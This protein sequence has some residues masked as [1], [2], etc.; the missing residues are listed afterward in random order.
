MK[1]N[2]TIEISDE[3][4]RILHAALEGKRGMATRQMVRDL[5]DDL[6]VS[7]CEVYA[8]AL[9]TLPPGKPPLEDRH[10]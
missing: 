8:S 6:V 4:R 2:H 10:R 7:A 5:V 1:V 9:D 3:Q